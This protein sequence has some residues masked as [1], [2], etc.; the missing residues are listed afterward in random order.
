MVVKTRKQS[1]FEA[2][3]QPAVVP[4]KR[5]VVLLLDAFLAVTISFGK[6]YLRGLLPQRIVNFSSSFSPPI[7]DPIELAIS[8]SLE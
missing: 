2:K 8:L 6:A 7:A 3:S 4:P 5:A 1:V